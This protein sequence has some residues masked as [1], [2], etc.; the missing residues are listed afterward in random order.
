MITK[1]LTIQLLNDNEEKVHFQSPQFLYYSDGYEISKF[2]GRYVPWHW[3]S[4]L[5]FS[6]VLQGQLRVK[7][8]HE[9]LILSAGEGCFINSNF[10]HYY[11]AM[12]KTD[13]IYFSQ[14]FDASILAG[15]A[16]SI[17]G[18]KYVQPIVYAGDLEIFHLRP[19]VSRQRKIIELLKAS[20]DTSEQQEFGYELKIRNYLSDAWI[21]LYREVE[22]LLGKTRRNDTTEL[23]IKMMISFVQTNFAEK[24]SLEDIASS[25][26]VSTREC[27]RCFHNALSKTPFQYLME[28]R[29]HKAA[30]LLAEKDYSITDIGEM[31]G[32]SSPSYFVK[33]FRKIMGVTP[34][35]FRIHANMN[36]KAEL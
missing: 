4:A 20:Q 32:F 28:Y 24:L 1:P 23:R 27:L 30:D 17:F 16:E 19:I 26:G 14:V 11:E 15:A 12:P 3:H 5:E 34:G 6:W 7:T 21:L 2:Y 22:S 13:C 29:V 33:T 10:L 8:N 9:E 25:A 18:M 35:D 31:C 36:Q